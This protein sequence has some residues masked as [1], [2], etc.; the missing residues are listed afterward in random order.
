MDEFDS[1]DESDERIMFLLRDGVPSLIQDAENLLHRL[2]AARMFL[3]LVSAINLMCAAVWLLASPDW[4]SRFE[5]TFAAA[6]CFGLGM[7]GVTAAAMFE[8][9]ASSLRVV[10]NE[11]IDQI[12]RVEVSSISSRR[13]SVEELVFRS[14]RVIMQGRRVLV[15]PFSEE[16]SGRVTGIAN[17]LIG[18]VPLF[19]E[20]IS[21][22]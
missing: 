12:H 17:F 13:Y 18:S 22:H 10:I 2:V 19:V 5:V 16:T 9:R 14:R 6:A 3:F 8:T 20:T 7:S 21:R 1:R 15:L 4:Y 11:L